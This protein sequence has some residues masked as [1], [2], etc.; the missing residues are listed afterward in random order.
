MKRNILFTALLSLFFLPV[1]SQPDSQLK[2]NNRNEGISVYQDRN[3]FYQAKAFD[4]SSFL[5]DSLYNKKI[6]IPKIPDKQLLFGRVPFR[7]PNAT[8]FNYNIDNMPILKPAGIYAPMKV[9]KPD[10]RV[11]YTLLIK[12]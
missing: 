2:L 12:E 10:P 3:P 8:Q 9:Y 1:F 11:R 5:K 4:F 6:F 7:E